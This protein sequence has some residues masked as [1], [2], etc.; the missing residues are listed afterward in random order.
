MVLSSELCGGS[1]PRKRRASVF[2]SIS[3]VCFRM[4][5]GTVQTLIIGSLVLGVLNFYPQKHFF[6]EPHSLGCRLFS[7]SVRYKVF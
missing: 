4:P 5:Y 6:A 3:R 2:H 7:V 1:F